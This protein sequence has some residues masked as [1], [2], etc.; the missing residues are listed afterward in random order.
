M[1]QQDFYESPPQFGPYRIVP[2]SRFQVQKRKEIWVVEVRRQDGTVQSI[3]LSYPALF[4]P[5][6]RVIVDGD[7][8]RAPE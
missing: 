8:I 1:K 5:G 3:K 7:E 6:D 4:Q 2:Q